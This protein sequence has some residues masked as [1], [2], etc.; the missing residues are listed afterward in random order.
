ML[1]GGRGKGLH[2]HGPKAPPF[3]FRRCRSLG[4]N[5]DDPVAVYE[6]VD[7]PDPDSVRRDFLEG[8]YH[9]PPYVSRLLITTARPPA[10]RYLCLAPI[11]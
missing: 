6:L 10:P 8:E 9:S 11:P 1:S 3:I 5:S 2:P 4:S 7:L